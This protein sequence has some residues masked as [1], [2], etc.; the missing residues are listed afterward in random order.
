MEFKYLQEIATI[1]ANGEKSKF[2]SIAAVSSLVRIVKKI[3]T[4]NKIQCGYNY[5]LLISLHMHLN[6]PDIFE[7]RQSG[8]QMALNWLRHLYKQHQ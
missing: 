3:G 8:G 6:I 4:Q 2:I 5:F 7:Q 1:S